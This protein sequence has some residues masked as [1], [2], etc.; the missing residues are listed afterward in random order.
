MRML[1]TTLGSRGDVKPI[2]GLAVQLGAPAMAA[3]ECDVP[4]VTGVIRTGEWR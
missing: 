1:L 2:V 4:V 3:E